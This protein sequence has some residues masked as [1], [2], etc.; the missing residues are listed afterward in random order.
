[1][2]MRFKEYYQGY[3]IVALALEECA[4]EKQLEKNLS[5]LYVTDTGIKLLPDGAFLSKESEDIEQLQQ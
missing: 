4:K 5:V 2:S 1:M 3:R